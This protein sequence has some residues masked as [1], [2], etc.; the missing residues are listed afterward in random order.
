MVKGKITREVETVWR[1]PRAKRWRAENL[2][3]GLYSRLYWKRVTRYRQ[4]FPITFRRSLIG[5]S[6]TYHEPNGS[7]MTVRVFAQQCVRGNTSKGAR[8]WKAALSGMK[9]RAKASE[10][11]RTWRKPPKRSTRRHAKRRERKPRYSRRGV[12][13]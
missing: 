8:F 7:D 10:P 1:H 11:D 9:A 2:S 4:P 6:A 13:L 5:A 12:R 3:E